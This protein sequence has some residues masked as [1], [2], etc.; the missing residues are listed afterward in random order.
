MIT[1][2]SRY[3]DSTVITTTVHGQ[4]A[5][6]IVPGA[7]TPQTFTFTSYQVTASDTADG[8]AQRYYG[9]ATLW[10]V[11]ADANPEQLWWGSMTPGTTIRIPSV[12]LQ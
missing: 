5:Q 2:G 7:Q 4:P 8:L 10:W 6:V 9:D 12:A 1:Q 11:I 3:T